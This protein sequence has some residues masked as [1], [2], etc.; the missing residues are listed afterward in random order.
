MFCQHGSN[1]MKVLLDTTIQINRMF[2]KNERELIERF[3]SENECYCSSYV[4][5]EFMS[6]II[7]DFVTLYSIMQI[8]D[9]L[10]EV[11]QRIAEV[12]SDRSKT[13]ML[14]LVNDL[15]REFDKDYE[16]IKEQL[17]IYP[18]R[19]I[20]RFYYGINE[21]LLDKTQ[22]ARAKANIKNKK[23]TLYLE[24]IRCRKT[25]NQCEI[26]AFWNHNKSSVK[27]LERKSGI[28][29]KMIPILEQLNDTDVIPKGNACKTMGDCIISLESLELHKGKVL[30]SNRKD[31]FPI[32]EH[33]GACL[34]EI[35]VSS[36]DN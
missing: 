11:Y 25:D 15:A 35:E 32:C 16:L 17:E 28:P 10:T 2:K 3:L 19:L 9:D 23:G 18:E 30:S 12:Y 36:I 7:N 13:R 31:F 6:N 14:Y 24:G 29:K 1:C 27:G 21:T 4:L 8:E 33:I 5:G 26:E 20:S 34:A 22:C